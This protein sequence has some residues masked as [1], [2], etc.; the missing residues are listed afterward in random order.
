[1]QEEFDWWRHG[2]QRELGRNR[3]LVVGGEKGERILALVARYW[4]DVSPL[5]APTSHLRTLM[6]RWEDGV[7]KPANSE[8]AAQHG[9][10]AFQA[11]SLW[12]RLGLERSVLHSAKLSPAISLCAAFAAVLGVTRSLTAA[13]VASLTIAQVVRE[14]APPILVNEHASAIG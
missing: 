2:A 14:Q 8:P 5:D 1:L 4:V 7:I 6:G 12:L 9:A 13:L 3:E 11:S 10:R